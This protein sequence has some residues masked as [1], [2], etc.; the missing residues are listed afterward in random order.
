M[1]NAVPEQ[2]I[3]GQIPVL[4]KISWSKKGAVARSQAIGGE[5][6]QYEYMSAFWQ[7]WKVMT[8]HGINTL[9]YSST[10]AT[11]G[12]AMNFN[13]NNFSTA[14]RFCGRAWQ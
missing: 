1:K 3:G 4:K 14:V 2:E 7:Y 11:Y 9:I 13:L 12:E 6:M 10:C 8:A 5:I